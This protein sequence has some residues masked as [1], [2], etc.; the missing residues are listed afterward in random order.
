M[1][2]AS[3]TDRSLPV[4]SHR[5]SAVQLFALVLLVVA[6]AGCASVDVVRLQPDLLLVPK[7]T[8]PVAAIQTSCI[9]FYF[10]TFGLP[11]ADL[12]I[13][14]NELLMKEAKKMGAD[15]VM[16]LHI[17]ATPG[18]GIW[19]LTKLFF[20]RSATAWAI[21]LRSEPGTAEGPG[22]SSL[23]PPLPLPPPATKEL[24]PSSR[25]TSK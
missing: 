22:L 23:P 9:G 1:R 19:W 7:G 10:F 20:F 8:E 16:D 4:E 24:A 15:R 21:A 3:E 17:D 14:V 12:D 18:G 6:L 25:P 5:A 11:Y 2:G 13:A